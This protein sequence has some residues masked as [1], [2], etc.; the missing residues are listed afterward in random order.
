MPRI[1]QQYIHSSIRFLYQ[2]AAEIKAAL[3]QKDSVGG[4]VT[5]V[6]RH[7]PPGWGEPVFDK[8]SA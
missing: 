1:V 5:C 7:V 4:I 2:M 6:C 3:D 8:V